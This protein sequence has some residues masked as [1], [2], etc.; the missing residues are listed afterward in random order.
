MAPLQTD[1][2]N[3][4]IILTAAEESWNHPQFFSF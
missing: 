1:A 3:F 2:S 4:N